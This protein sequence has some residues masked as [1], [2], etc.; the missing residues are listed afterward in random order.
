MII[1]YIKSKLV[2]EFKEKL[3]AHGFKLNSILD[4]VS[5]K[6]DP[7]IKRDLIENWPRLNDFFAF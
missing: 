4:F 1:C 3:A 6:L 2:K 7:C 5:S